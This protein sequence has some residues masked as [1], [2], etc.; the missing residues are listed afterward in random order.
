MMM[1]GE[2]PAFFFFSLFRQ[3]P[4]YKAYIEQNRTETKKNLFFTE[5]TFYVES[6][7]NHNMLWY[8]DIE[9]HK[10]INSVPFMVLKFDILRTFV[11]TNKN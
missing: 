8:I 7:D 9:K 4:F 10:R 6:V 11:L 2:I 5:Q 3:T 1:Q